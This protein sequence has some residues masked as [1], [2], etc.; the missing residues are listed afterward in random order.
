MAQPNFPTPPPQLPEEIKIS[1]PAPKILL[2]TLSREPAL[3]AINTEM[4]W[5]L[6]N[7][8]VWLDTQPSLICA[9]LTGKGRAFCAGADLKEWHEGRQG[10][11]PSGGFGG[12]S[13]RGGKKPVIC[14]VNGICFGGG[15][16]MIINADIV[17]ASGKAQFALPE[18]TIGV[19]ALQGALPRLIRTVGRQRATEMALTGRRLGAQEAKEWG[20]VNKVVPDG[21]DVVAEAVKMASLI[22]SHSPDAVIVSREGLKMGWEGLGAEEA[23]KI[24]G[25][26]WYARM[27]DGENMKEGVRSF[28]DK[29]K[30]RWVESKL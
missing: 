13:R 29:R 12:L 27:Y 25:E 28:V 7:L 16:E 19:T 9:I 30:P 3:N 2:I 18:V 20:L 11:T 24:W 6:H 10:K 17:I 26:S 5:A 14:A 22:A 15:C 21:Q 23:T 4:H 8:Y 1:F